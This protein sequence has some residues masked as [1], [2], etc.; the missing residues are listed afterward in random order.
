V[1]H[2]A[3][4]VARRR[5]LAVDGFRYRQDDTKASDDR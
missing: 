2:L 4:A 5:G 1:Q 3:R